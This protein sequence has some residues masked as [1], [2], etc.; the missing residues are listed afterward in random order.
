MNGV[1]FWAG[2]EADEFLTA[3]VIDER[4]FPNWHAVGSGVRVVLRDVEDAD[5]VNA[6]RAD[7]HP[8][9]LHACNI[10]LEYLAGKL[11]LERAVGDA[12][13][14]RLDAGKPVVTQISTDRRLRHVR[15]FA[16]EVGIRLDDDRRKFGRDL[17]IRHEFGNG[18]RRRVRQ[19]IDLSLSRIR[20][21]LPFGANAAGGVIDTRRVDSIECCE[22]PHLGGCPTARKAGHCTSDLLFVRF[23]K[24]CESHI[25]IGVA[26]IGFVTGQSHQK[27]HNEVRK[28]ARD[29]KD[30]PVSGRPC[31]RL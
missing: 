10:E 5:L 27:K 9:L 14:F 6:A 4:E 30:G 15:H 12:A 28:S 2:D 21:S 7:I 25:K 23:R 1:R 18:T 11:C 29:K 8:T 19:Q 20:S 17:L 31:L 16:E 24:F 22:R 26:D 3:L 13:L